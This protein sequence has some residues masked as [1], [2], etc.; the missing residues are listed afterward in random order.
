MKKSG[1]FYAYPVNSKGFLFLSQGEEGGQ[2]REDGEK[3]GGRQ[4]MEG[5]WE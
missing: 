3:E 4:G 2:E 5:N 1:K